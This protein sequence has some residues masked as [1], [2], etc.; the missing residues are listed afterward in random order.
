MS[1][2]SDGRNHHSAISSEKNLEIYK[3]ELESIYGRKI[4]NFEHR[5]GTMHKEDVIIYFDD[6]TFKKLSLKVKKTGLSVGSFDY[7]NTSNFNRDIF[8]N[9]FN[10]Y[11]HYK[12]SKNLKAE[13]LLKE[14]CSLDLLSITSDDLTKFFIE[15]VVEKYKD[16]DLIIIDGKHNKIYKTIPPVF[17]YVL[18][19]GKLSIFN[20]EKITQSKQ[21]YAKSNDGLVN[22]F[23]LRIRFHLNNGKSKWLG[24]QNGSSNLVI[25]FQQDKV[26]SLI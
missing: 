24:L 16:I 12:N 21:I 18:N 23:N 7:V 14:H 3:S 10:T 17:G 2:P 19:G 4:I 5:G 9:S 15:N 13:S 22:L 20:N 1:F 6:S 11:E 8:P 26:E 25:K